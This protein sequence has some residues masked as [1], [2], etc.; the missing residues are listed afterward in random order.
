MAASYL[1][2][3]RQ[4]VSTIGDLGRGSTLNPSSDPSAF[5]RSYEIKR[6]TKSQGVGSSEDTETKNVVPLVKV[7][8]VPS[9]STSA[10]KHIYVNV[11]LYNN[12]DGQIIP[13]QYQI[14]FDQPFLKNAEKYYLSI[15][16][17]SFPTTTIPLFQFNSTTDTVLTAGHQTSL[18]EYN[19]QMVTKNDPFGVGNF[20]RPI[21]IIQSLDGTY[22]VSYY[23]QFLDSLNVALLQTFCQLAVDDSSF[24]GTVPPFVTFDASSNKFKLY[25]QQ[26]VY[27]PERLVLDDGAS[28]AMN[29]KTYRLFNSFPSTPVNIDDVSLVQL[30]VDSQGGVNQTS[31]SPAVNPLLIGSMNNIIGGLNVAWNSSFQYGFG[32]VVSY[33]GNYYGSLTDGNINFVPTA[34]LGTVWQLI[35]TTAL[36]SGTGATIYDST[37][38]YVKYQL[39][40]Y[41][42]AD[43]VPYI[44]KVNSNIG[45]TPNSSSGQWLQLYGA[46]N[47]TIYSPTATYYAGQN[48]YYPSV[49]GTIYTSVTGLAVPNSGNFDLVVQGGT[50]TIP[51]ILNVKVV[52]GT[53]VAVNSFTAGNYSAFP[54][55]P[56]TALPAS[57]IA[58][59]VNATF[60]LTTSGTS[61]TGAVVASSGTGYQSIGSNP[62]IDLTNWVVNT[63]FN[64]NTIVGTYSTLG[65]WA[66]FQSI[67]IQ[68]SSLPV[69]FETY[70]PPSQNTESGA[71]ASQS[72]S[73]VPR[74]V[75]TDL[76]LI[77]TA[78]GFDRT[79]LQYVPPGQYRLID[80]F[81][82]PE[83]R[84]IDSY[85]QYMHQ[86]LTFSDLLMLPGDS[87]RIKYL[88]LLN[89][90]FTLG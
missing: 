76:D 68:S 69:R 19:V 63:E 24:N 90:S 53:V 44:S 21:N 20:L 1:A 25:A 29:Y 36:N 73:Q 45:N 12:L 30:L 78:D 87:F 31:S 83:L 47:P 35:C 18:S 43:S 42:T 11:S 56:V 77:R 88:F 80:M 34:S 65:N 82:R 8:V 40:Y 22:S 70:A 52:A 66:D 10:P 54:S 4:T 75:L 13:A 2:E 85:I 50:Q 86:D 38:E 57:G 7:E 26:N 3:R 72:G 41:P 27:T 81:A 89:D 33:S 15:V 48:V 14:D 39:V 62:S 37:A 58:P 9:D 79:P 74:P 17:A 84:Q 23:Q 59:V 61:V 71:G 16:K 51:S 55:N 60:T 64:S 49:N 67:V 46:G 32:A 28:I 5:T 6:E